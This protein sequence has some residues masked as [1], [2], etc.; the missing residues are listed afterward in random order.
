M[1]YV[2]FGDSIA[3]SGTWEKAA[4]NVT[5]TEVKIDKLEPKDALE[6]RIVAKNQYGPAEPSP[7]AQ[8][9]SRAS[10]S[11]V[12]EAESPGNCFKLYFRDNFSILRHFLNRSTLSDAMMACERLFHNCGAHT[13]NALSL[14]ARL[15]VGDGKQRLRRRS[16]CASRRG[17]R[18]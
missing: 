1:K 15:E 7:T 8:L 12:H 3:E 5:K 6:F 16:E 17:K 14:K 13:E 2:C 9:S 10:K 11:C 4:E 18:N